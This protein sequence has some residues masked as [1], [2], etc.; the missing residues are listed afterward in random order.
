MNTEPLVS[1]LL[2]TYNQQ[3]FIAQAIESVL[4]QKV[5]F[6]YEIV[7]GEDLGSDNTRAICESY[8]VKYDFI[9]V[10]PRT[11]N[12]GIAGNWC[13][14]A[15]HALGKYM[16]M[17]DGDDYWTDPNKMQMQVD[18]MEAHPECVICHTNTDILYMNTGT[19]KPINKRDVPEGMI[20]HDVMGG[21]EQ[22]TSSTMCLR[23]EEV[24][25]HI[26]FDIY[27]KE[28]FPC[29]DWPTIAILSAY[30]E[31]RYM[32]QSTTV[33][34]VGQASVTN[35]VNYDKIRRY[36]QR[37]KHMTECLYG[38]LPELGEFKDGPYFDTYMYNTLLNAAYENDDYKEA[39]EFAAKNPYKK[40]FA[41]ICAKFWVMFKL[42]RL[43]H[44][45]K[46]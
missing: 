19:I 23:T 45:T 33:Y 44:L 28:D 12:L 10:L 4:M 43:Y 17:L 9:H 16:M 34:R 14:C 24:K 25:K 21:R 39:K 40:R 26:P 46:K 8:A 3:D 42:Y 2:I 20:L 13:D 18:F 1:V 38:L 41:T 29:E 6:P 36:W 32:P 11:K 35:E 15:Q 37:S 27:V 22:M 7:I 31:I 5:N 30:G